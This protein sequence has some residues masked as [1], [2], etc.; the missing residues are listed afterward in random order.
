MYA[1]IELQKSK[2]GRI[3]LFG[4]IKSGGGTGPTKPG[5]LHDAS[6]RSAAYARC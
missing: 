4:L 3:L 5:N 6:L 1:I 2:A